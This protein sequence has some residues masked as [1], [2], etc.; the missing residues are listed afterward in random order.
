MTGKI[1]S[2]WQRGRPTLKL[3]F[4]LNHQCLVRIVDLL[5]EFGGDGV[6]SGRVL[7]DET[8]VAHNG[9]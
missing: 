5:I 2:Y 7:D 1:R 4:I 8:L 6:M 9:L 3:D